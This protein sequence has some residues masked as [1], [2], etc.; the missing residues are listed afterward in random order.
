MDEARRGGLR[1]M[2]DDQDEWRE[3]QRVIEQAKELNEAIIERQLQEL[4]DS[5]VGTSAEELA[6]LRSESL[7]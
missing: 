3:A 5:V 6:R 7:C 1:L 2:Q 4:D